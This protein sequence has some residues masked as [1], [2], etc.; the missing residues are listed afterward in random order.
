MWA[1]LGAKRACRSRTRTACYPLALLLRRELSSVATSLASSSTTPPPTP[2]ASTTKLA[3]PT[4]ADLYLNEGDNVVVAVSG[5]V[6][7]SV[8]LR[9]LSELVSSRHC[10]QANVS[11]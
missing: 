8:T 2:P 9:L 10:T 7:S 3:L 11:R 5:G 6:D 4:L 1:A